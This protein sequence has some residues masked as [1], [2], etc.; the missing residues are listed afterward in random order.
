MNRTKTIRSYPF[1]PQKTIINPIGQPV[2]VDEQLADFL[3]HLWKEDY[4]TVYSCQSGH[5]EH[6][7]APPTRFRY[8]MF[9][10]LA[11][12]QRFQATYGGHVDEMIY[13]ENRRCVRSF[14][15]PTKEQLSL[16][17]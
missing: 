5:P 16:S 10:N 8:I 6:G 11:D 4:V 17:H 12:A 2:D 7:I 14:E 13:H 1:H 15:I 3:E 9:D